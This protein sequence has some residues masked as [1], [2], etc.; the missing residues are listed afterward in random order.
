MY[1]Y[2]YICT[3]IYIY[4][5]YDTAV[6]VGEGEVLLGHGEAAFGRCPQPQN[7]LLEAACQAGLLVGAP[8]HEPSAATFGLLK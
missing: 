4:T 1:I 2:I 5:L 7:A 3:Y 6:G 8:V